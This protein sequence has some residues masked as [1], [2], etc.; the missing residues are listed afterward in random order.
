MRTV[1]GGNV[2]QPTSL[3]TDLT[4]A[5]RIEVANA[6]DAL[7]DLTEFA[8]SLDYDSSVDEIVD[9]ATVV[10]RR[11]E[12]VNSLAPLMTASPPVALGRRIV[13]SINPGSGTYTEV[14]R[15]KI[16]DV[17]W[18][19]RFGDVTVL[20]RDQA[21]VAMDTWIEIARP[22]GSTTGVSLE[23]V[24]QAVADDNLAA[25]PTLYFPVASS[26]VVQHLDG[27]PPY[28]PTEQST[29][30]ALRALAESIGWTVRWR[31]FGASA[32]DWRHTVFGP[33]RTKTVA[34][35]T[36]GTSDYWD[37]T[38]MRQAVEDI[39]NAVE[40]LYIEE[41]VQKTTGVLVDA[42]S[43]AKYGRRYMKITEGTGSPINN[44]TTATALGNAALSDLKEPDALLEITGRYFWPGEIGVDL[45]TFTANNKH[46]STDQKLAAMRFMHR[47]AVG[48][49]PTTKILTRGKPSGG[50]LMWRRRLA[51]GSALP[52]V[53]EMRVSNFREVARTETDVTF[54]WDVAGTITELWL[55][56]STPAQPVATDPWAVL[57]GVPTARLT[58]ATVEYTVPIPAAGLVTY[59]RLIPI[60]ADVA[61]GQ[62]WDFTVQGAAVALIQRATIVSTTATQ[63][64]VRVAVANPVTGTD[65][66]IAYNAG[67]LTV[68][69]ASGQTIVA[70]NVTS[71]LATTGTVDF[72]ITRPAFEA[73]A[74]R[75]TFTA[76][77]TDRVADV[78]AVDVPE[79]QNKITTKTLRLAYTMFLPANIGPGSGYDLSYG[80]QSAFPATADLITLNA[81]FPLPIGTT[82]TAVR[83][84]LKRTNGDG[85]A[86]LLFYQLPDP[87]V[88]GVSQIGST[89]LH[90][91]TGWETLTI[92]S[93]STTVAIDKLYQI[94]VTLD[95][96]GSTNPSDNQLAWAEVDYTSPS[97]SVS[98]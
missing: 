73:G 16:D 28:G 30:D 43:I 3:L 88:G 89:Q 83:A 87:N 19:E 21:G 59:G 68:T 34:D 33:S 17:D 85:S 50:V 84:R 5:V 79:S 44:V 58:A 2:A 92:G 4:D 75:V 40:V 57:A 48:E 23:T 14:F 11:L 60:D 32:S 45:Y 18:P 91:T 1:S 35:H 47:I 37:V 65:I 90:S 20:C 67:G 93:L 8:V 80:S 53:P 95:G 51:L 63:I 86:A 82:V 74:G 13:V 22:Y 25:P 70:A 24:M 49:R 42:P 54:G 69:P 31:H 76:S 77:S 66:T 52:L 41:G 81:T 10:F 72:T 55:Y 26:A 39:R 61:R 9:G 6:A 7:V 46:F 27:D 96:A 29:L 38:T 62:S 36:F 94:V 56:L 64:V 12:G 97:L 15:G 71:S 98:L 78:D